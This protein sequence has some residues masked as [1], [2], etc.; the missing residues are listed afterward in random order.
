MQGTRLLN[1]VSE[2]T[3][4][5]TNLLRQ[6]RSGDKDANGK[7]MAALQ[8]ELRQLA[9]RAMRHERPGHTLQPTAL[10]NEAFIRLASNSAIESKDR[11]HFLAI[12]ARL[13]REILVD[14][15]RRR[16]AQ[17]RGS[18]MKMTL[19]DGLALADDRLDDVIGCDELLGR[20]EQLDARQ[21]RIV[22]LRFFAGLSV[23]EVADILEIS[24]PTVKR[25][26]ASARAWL[27]RELTARRA[28]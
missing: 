23:E 15:A 17:K 3:G 25:E 24:A 19:D 20:L 27:H 10:V 22:E 12:A 14:Y 4:D 13:M 8:V 28:P 11:A 2:T 21:A 5:I 18:G 16:G 6:V 7:L 26:W 9:A 1:T